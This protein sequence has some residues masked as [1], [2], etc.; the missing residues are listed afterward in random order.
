MAFPGLGV[1]STADTMLFHPN[2]HKT[3]NSAVEMSQAFQDIALVQ[4]HRS[5]KKNTHSMP[6]KTVNSNECFTILFNDAYFL[7]AAMIVGDES[8]RLRMA[9]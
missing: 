6:F 9:N 2:T 4:I 3:G 1:F 5:K 7:L 8:I